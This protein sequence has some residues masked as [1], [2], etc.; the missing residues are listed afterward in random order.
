[1][2]PEISDVNSYDG[3]ALIQE[4]RNRFPILDDISGRF[5][6]GLSKERIPR[7]FG[8][9]LAAATSSDRGACCFVLDKTPGTSA[10]AAVF[11][12]LFQLQRDFPRLAREYADMNLTRGQLVK[13]N[14]SSFV[15]EYEG[16]WDGHPDKFRL[17]VQDKRDWRSFQVTDLLRL[18]PTTRKRPKG[19]LTSKLGEFTRS[20]IDQLLGVGTQG[21]DSM[22]RN[23]V[24]LYMAQAQFSR[25]ADV[26]SLGTSRATWS[27]R[28]SNF[29]PWGAVGS[30]GEIR[31]GDDYQVVGEP[32][33]GVGRVLQDLADAAMASPDGSK[34][35]VVDGARGATGDLQAFD[36]IVERHRVVIL[37]SPSEM[38]DIELLREQECPIWYL[39]P[40]E[41]MI[42]ENR[43]RHRSRLSLAGRTVRLAEIRERSDIVAVD[44]ENEDLLEAAE[45]MERVAATVRG[46]DETSEA[47]IL[48]ASLYGLLLEISECCFGVGS[49]TRTELSQVS[50][51]LAR[52]RMW[53]T[54][55]T[56]REF[57]AVL[58]RLNEAVDGRTG[59]TH[60][61]EVLLNTIGESK[62]LWA[63]ASRST[64][65]AESLRQGLGGL[66]GMPSILPL[67]SINAEDEWDGIILACWPGR[68]RFSRLN[69]LA[70]ARD[71][72]IL[73]Y[74]FERR[75]FLGHEA[76]EHALRR[77]H[78]MEAGDRA[79]ILGVDPEI[80]PPV[81]STYARRPVDGHSQA[82]P[83][84]DF[85]R[86]FSRRRHSRPSSA[87]E[88]DVRLARLVEFFG[89]CY[90]L[91]S[92]WS[93]LH[94]L[95]ELMGDRKGDGH[96]LRTVSASELSADDFVLFR[97]G[98]GK[99][100]VRMLAEDT[101]GI[102]EYERV[103]AIAERWKPALRRLG[104]TS[105]AVQ[106]RLERFRLHRTLPTING[107]MDN[108]DLIGP[109]NLNDI[110]VIGEAADDSEL[111]K[112][113]QL[114]GDAVT[115]IRGAHIAAGSR[116]T[117]L[118]LGEVR[119]RLG[120]LDDQPVLLDLGYGKA[121]VVRVQYVDSQTREYS[122]DQVNRLIGVDDSTL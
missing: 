79:G 51:N 69:N 35:V 24:L 78:R 42:G 106:G 85:E 5:G 22:I 96:R 2:Q 77:S 29:L 45:A 108:P 110:K 114:V 21:N 109:G 40:E 57:Q 115:R 117:Q 111:R 37:A 55:E 74:P 100:F 95:N 14:P 16:M 17:K 72:R 47:D 65:S 26:V 36:D 3:E 8:L 64:R 82:Q 86:G 34:V 90:A 68:R 71:M 18:E 46:P 73:A 20:T 7:F 92:E 75:W 98:G 33:I 70:A 49:E 4:L 39:S 104:S 63:I 12:A 122:T 91:L 19:T 121:W 88:G 60:K 56:Y 87:V 89:G 48:L 112:S 44:C 81:R 83:M 97:A 6:N 10:L 15:Y 102:E 41:V 43:P 31:A 53:M 50:E 80:L 113:V 118:I 66:A 62:G 107:W 11:L 54:A 84:L 58:D 25:V 13:V 93:Q 120:Q 9:L 67:Q 76:R 61:A 23:V 101:L 32:L 103:R 28:L 38:E 30:G 94:V 119:D 52:D 27:D 1:M 59:M 99:E 105:A 116:L